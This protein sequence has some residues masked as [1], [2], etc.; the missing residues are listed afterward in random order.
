[1]SIISG[2][3]AAKSTVLAS[4][5]STPA[6]SAAVRVGDI[7]TGTV[8]QVATQSVD[9]SGGIVAVTKPGD[10]LN[11]LVIDVPST[12]YSG[13]STFK[14]SSAPI[15]SQTFGSDITPISPMIYVDNGGVYSDDLMYVR[16]RVKVPNGYFAM[17]F[18]YD[19]AT[20]QLQGMPLTSSHADSVTVDTRHFFNFFISM[21]SD[22]LLNSEIDSGFR[23]GIDDWQ[24]TNRGSYIAPGGNCEGQSLTALWYYCT[25]PDGAHSLYGRYDNNG[26]QPATPSLWQDDSLGYRFASI[27]QNDIVTNGKY[28]NALWMNLGGKG[29]KQDQNGKWYLT[30]FPA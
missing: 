3:W 29:M 17:G 30:M 12:S 20:K 18:Y 7:K 10:P 6:T 2:I 19:P 11:G 4:A 25:K 24:F 27:T 14:V 26:D 16:V 22:T 9:S 21:I 1:M 15:T 8:V 23:P 28:A 5:S 13:N